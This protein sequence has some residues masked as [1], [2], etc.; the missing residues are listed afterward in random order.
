MLIRVYQ[1]VLTDLVSATEGPLMVGYIAEQ[2][3]RLFAEMLHHVALVHR[4]KEIN[5]ALSI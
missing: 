1:T 2:I 3:T 4:P 5:T